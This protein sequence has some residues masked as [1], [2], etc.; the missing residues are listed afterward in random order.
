M[1]MTEATQAI[2]EET[3]EVLPVQPVRPPGGLDPSDVKQQ[4]EILAKASRLSHIRQVRYWL[5]DVAESYERC[6][7]TFEE[8][9][10]LDPDV[11]L[12]IELA[13]SLTPG[14]KVLTDY[15]PMKLA[16]ILRRDGDWS[17]HLIASF[18]QQMQM[19]GQGR[20]DFYENLPAASSTPVVVW[21]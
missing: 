15:G 19:P 1:T 12:A 7:H 5:A 2:D 18:D 6:V 3:G 11:V 13:G 20:R 16:R 9:E 4:A 10:S 17:L 14:M 21:A 8:A